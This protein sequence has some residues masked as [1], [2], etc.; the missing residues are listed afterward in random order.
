MENERTLSNTETILSATN[1]GLDDNKPLNHSSFT[2]AA[3]DPDERFSFAGSFPF[4][5][6]CFFF[7]SA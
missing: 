2:S 4:D 5:L 7:D 6:A 3:D 1:N